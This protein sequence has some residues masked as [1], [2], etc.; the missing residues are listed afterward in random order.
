MKRTRERWG[1]NQDFIAKI[2]ASGEFY[3]KINQLVI[4]DEIIMG[5]IFPSSV[6]LHFGSW[7]WLYQI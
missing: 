1:G 3:N 6:P 7:L 5:Y 2:D 4:D